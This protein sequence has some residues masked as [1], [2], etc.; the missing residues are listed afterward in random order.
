M[1]GVQ[2]LNSLAEMR[3]PQTLRNSVSTVLEKF[4]QPEKAVTFYREF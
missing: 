4:Q 1:E 2:C 3:Q